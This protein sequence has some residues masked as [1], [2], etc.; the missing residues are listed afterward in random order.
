MEKFHLSPE[1]IAKLTDRQIAE[2]YYHKRD[3]HGSLVL[4][5]EQES[6]TDE[7]A[8]SMFAIDQFFKAGL[9]KPEDA[10]I[11]REKLRKKFGRE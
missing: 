3:K 2:L 8:S 5:E 9:L 7:F 11:A 10:E 1:Q 6:N 4:D